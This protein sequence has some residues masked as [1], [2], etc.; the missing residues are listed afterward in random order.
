MFRWIVPLALI[1]VV[2]VFGIKYYGSTDTDSTQ[3]VSIGELQA[4]PEKYEDQSVKVR[5]VVTDSIGILKLGTFN[6]R[7]ENGLR[8][9]MITASK[10]PKDGTKFI[11]TGVFRKGITFGTFQSVAIFVEICRS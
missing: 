5:G 11:C 4:D 10:V 6:L 8:I 3:E 1:V 9:A 2:V 7:D